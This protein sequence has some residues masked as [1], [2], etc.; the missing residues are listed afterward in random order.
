MLA[1]E[2]EKQIPEIARPLSPLV[3]TEAQSRNLLLAMV[4]VQPA[5]VLALGI[6]VVGV[7]RW[8]G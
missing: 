2:R 5:L 3:L 1:G 4:M 6:G 8:R 7:R